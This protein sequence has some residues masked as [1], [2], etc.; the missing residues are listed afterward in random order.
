[1]PLHYR[2]VYACYEPNNHTVLRY[3]GQTQFDVAWR[4]VGHRGPSTIDERGGWFRWVYRMR[5]EPHIVE[6]ETVGARTE[7]RCKEKALKAESAWI[8]SLAPVSPHILNKHWRR[9]WMSRAGVSRAAQQRYAIAMSM[10]TTPLSRICQVS[11][12]GYFVESP[13]DMWDVHLRNNYIWNRPEN[14]EK[15]DAVLGRIR[16]GEQ[17]ASAMEAMYPAVSVRSVPKDVPPP[18]PELSGDHHGYRRLALAH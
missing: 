11:W 14:R 6:L 1:M 13:G 18:V 3:I 9:W 4:M 5:H 16:R 7:Q 2:T 12:V 10:A 17:I 15:R 8:A